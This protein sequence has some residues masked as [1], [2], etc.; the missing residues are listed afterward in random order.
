M[1][2]SFIFVASE[3]RPAPL[4][5]VLAPVRCLRVCPAPLGDILAPICRLRVLPCALGRRFRPF[6]LP[7]V[8]GGTLGQR[9][10]PFSLPVSAGRHPWATFMPLSV[11]CEC[12]AAPLGDVLAPVRCLRVPG[13]TLGRRFRPFSLPVSAGRHPWATFQALSVAC[14]CRAA[15]LGDILPDFGPIALTD[16]ATASKYLLPFAYGNAVKTSSLLC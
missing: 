2:N 14:E 10:C 5:N 7:V 16:R 8:P 6:S 12:R 4:G 15:P 3:C 13:D 9:F 11:A 1:T